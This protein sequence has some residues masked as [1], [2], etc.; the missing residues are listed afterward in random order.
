MAIHDSSFNAAVHLQTIPE[1]QKLNYLISCLKGSALQAVRGFDIAPENYEVVRKL[2]TEKYGD[3]SMTTK[4][5]CNA[6]QSIKRNK[7]EWIETVEKMERIFR[8]LEVLGENLEHSSIESVVVSRLPRWILDKVYHQKTND[9]P[10]S[11]LKLR[12]FLG[13][14][15]QVNEEVR[16][17]FTST[18]ME[19][20]P[21]LSKYKQ[22]PK[23]YNETSALATIHN[24][25]KIPYSIK[26][27]GENETKR[28]CTFCN[29]DHWDSECQVYPTVKSRMERL[30]ETKKCIVCLKTH[31]GEECRRKVKCFYCKAAHNSALCEKRN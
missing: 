14:L 25:K 13:K 30:K 21:I 16:N 19:R 15:I 12:R 11:I 1:I 20:K 7:K 26:K 17:Q 18:Q 29:Q 8:Q 28:P 4:L 2:L 31:Q 10:W 23:G 6:L 22:T 9:S 3:S 5:L 24:E 27:R